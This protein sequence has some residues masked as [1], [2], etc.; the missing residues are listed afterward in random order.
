MVLKLLQHVAFCPLI[1]TMLLDALLPCLKSKISNPTPAS[2]A[3]TAF[4]PGMTVMENG[5]RP[6]AAGVTFVKSLESAP[7]FGSTFHTAINP[8]VGGTPLTEARS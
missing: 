5:R 6:G 3:S 4:F 2:V 7:L 8:G 1:G